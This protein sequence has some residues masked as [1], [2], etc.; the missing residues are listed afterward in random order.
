MIG[1]DETDIA[2][3]WE[4]K[5]SYGEG[6]PDEM[7]GSSSYFQMELKCTDEGNVTGCCQDEFTLKLFDKP[8]SIKGF[9]E[10]GS[11]TF[12][13]TYPSAFFTDGPD[14][15][16]ILKDEPSHQVLYE[17][18]LIKNRTSGTFCFKGKW[19]IHEFRIDKT[20]RR[21]EYYGSGKWEMN[22]IN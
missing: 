9:F 4:G 1:F 22:K 18:F 20:F 3:K 5:F 13:K 7:I 14:E 19:D 10:H 8:A 17:G 6:Y 11:I 15:I 21:M 2:G 12:I 16:I